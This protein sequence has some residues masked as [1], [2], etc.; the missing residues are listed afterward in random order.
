[1]PKQVTVVLGGREYTIRE[2][3]F[4]V[5]A[6]WS[7]KLD[8]S[9]VVL[10]FKSLDG[11]VEDLVSAIKSRPDGGSWAE[12]DLGK[13]VSLA[14]VLPSTMEAMLHSSRDIADLLFEYEPKLKADRKW[15]EQNA[16]QDELNAAFIEI[17]KMVFPIM[18]VW[19]TVSG[20]LGRQTSGNLPSASTVS[21][22]LP[23][24]GPKKPALAT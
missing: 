10:L 3:P 19:A 8:K 11:F 23:A 1:M 2:K 20:S 21:N 6:T 14:R 4:G 24:S 13:I 18:D 9:R 22:G 5:H 7:E 17:L 15:L 16:Y 12:M